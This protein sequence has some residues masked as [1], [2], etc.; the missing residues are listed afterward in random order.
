ME[1]KKQTDLHLVGTRCGDTHLHERAGRRG[2]KRGS[3]EEAGVVFL[4]A[5]CGFLPD[6]KG[7]KGSEEV[8]RD[9]RRRHVPGGLFWRRTALT[10]RGTWVVSREF[11]RAKRT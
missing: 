2:D 11:L 7:E 3:S 5:E 4:T 10:S 1:E 8:Q 6:E 9:G